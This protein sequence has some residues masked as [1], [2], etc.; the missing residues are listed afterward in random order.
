MDAYTVRLVLW[1]VAGGLMAAGVIGVALALLFDRSLSEPV[2]HARVRRP[3]R[4]AAAAVVT[5][6]AETPVDEKTLA[7]RRAAYLQG[8]LVLVGLAILTALEF[9][10]ATAAGGSVVLLFLVALIKAGL[11]LQY[12]MHLRK[13]WGEEAHG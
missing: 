10:I 3:A 9:V 1:I 6:V 5:R 8:I 13:V 7:A 2:E 4:P 11:I 12:Y